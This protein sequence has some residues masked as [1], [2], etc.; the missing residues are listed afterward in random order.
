[1]VWAQVNAEGTT[2]L[3]NVSI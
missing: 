1:M 3:T 2:V